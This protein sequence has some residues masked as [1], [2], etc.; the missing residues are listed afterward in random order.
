M[1]NWLV[2]RNLSSVNGLPYRPNRSCQNS[3]GVPNLRRT[4][5]EQKGRYD[6]LLR[7]PRGNG[8]SSPGLQDAGR[9][10]GHRQPKQRLLPPPENRPAASLSGSALA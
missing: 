3:A 10:C 6:Y 9:G 1:F 5:A 8:L 7:Q 4:S 2:V